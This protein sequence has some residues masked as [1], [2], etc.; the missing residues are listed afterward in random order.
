M[1]ESAVLDALV[2]SL[3]TTLVSLV[4]VIVCGT[5]FALVIHRT[6]GALSGGLE[7]LV[8]LPAIMP[9]SV[10]GIALLLAFGRQGLLGST[11]SHWGI[12][13]A[14]TPIAV[15]MAQTFVAAPFYVR[16][17]A[18][19]FQAIDPTYLEAATLD[20]ASAWQSLRW[21]TLPVIAPF[22]LTGAVL[23]WA[24]ALGEFGATI[25]FAGSLQGVTQTLPLAIYLGFETDLEQAKAI[26]VLLLVAAVFL[27]VLLRLVLRRRLVYAH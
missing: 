2:I 14:F 11:F 9:P 22:L 6:R 17:A 18:N 10:A 25:L 1:H 7:V 19:A 13:I 20:G 4:L 5:A 21:V 24:R 23:A 12:S 8:T 16:E 3:K 26:A 15:V 27:L